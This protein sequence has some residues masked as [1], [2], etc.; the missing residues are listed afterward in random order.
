MPRGAGD[1]SRLTMAFVT[2]LRLPF[3]VTMGYEIC[4]PTTRMLIN[5]SIFQSRTMVTTEAM[6]ARCG[7]AVDLDGDGDN[8]VVSASSTD[9]TVA[10]F[11]NQHSNHS[12]AFSG[13]KQI[14]FQ[15][16]GARIVDFGDMDGDGIV[17]V[18][19]ASYY[20][21]IIRWF[22]NS[23]SGDFGAGQVVS[24]TAF[25]AQGVVVADVNG[26][27]HLDLASASSGDNTVAWY[28]NLGGG[29]FCEVK[30]LVDT[31]AQGVRTVVAADLNGDGLIDLASAAKDDNTIAWYPNA[32]GGVFH[33]KIVI[34]SAAMGA[35][36]LIAR[37]IDQDG[38]MD[39]VLASNADDTVAIYRNTD[40]MGNFVRTDHSALGRRL[41]S[42]RVAPRR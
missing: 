10:W 26:D 7:I 5:D 2:C 12:L 25:N 4:T 34:N 6:G 38:K 33:Q 22:K 31:T 23:G 30:H 21:H 15:S 14:T 27:G 37:D 41:A 24:R 42:H 18:V 16:N 29:R 39:L 3:S 20:D 32:G 8:D 1:R 36:S 19:A 28:E 11:K 9:N 40:A 13:K 17:D 35:Y